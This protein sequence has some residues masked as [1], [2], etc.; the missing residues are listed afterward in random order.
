MAAVLAS[1]TSETN[2]TAGAKGEDRPLSREEV[3]ARWLAEIPWWYWPWGHL[4]FPSIVGSL[5]IA[6]AI[7]SVHDLRAWQALMVPAVL[8]LSN[9]VEWRVHKNVL[10]RRQWPLADLYYRHTPNHHR[11]FVTDDMVV[12]SPREFRFVLL[13]FWAIVAILCLNAP[14]TGGLLLAG[15]QN[16]AA[17]YVATTT[18]YILSY[19]W[20]HLAYHLP[21]SSFVGRRVG[22]LRRHHATHHDPSLMQSWNFNVT[23]PLWDWIRGTIHAK[24]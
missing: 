1:E 22:A 15:Q 20:L 12:R 21:P 4:A 13:P 14:I 17:L 5:V 10:H 7:R 24:R 11:V 2:E 8:L 16:L 6:F 3:R 23:V 19:E 18:A 9:A